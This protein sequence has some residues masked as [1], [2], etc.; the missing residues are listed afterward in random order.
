MRFRYSAD[1]FEDP[2]D[3]VSMSGEGADGISGD[4]RAD[5]LA[6]RR[7]IERAREQGYLSDEEQADV[8][9]EPGGA[10]AVDAITS[11]LAEMNVPVL[12][13]AEDAPDLPD[14]AAVEA[15]NDLFSTELSDV[16]LSGVSLDDPVRIYLREIGR[17]QLLPGAQEVALAQAME[18][19]DYIFRLQ[20]EL[21]GGNGDR[22]S[23]AGIGW[24]VYRTLREGWPLTIAFYRAAFPDQPATTKTRDLAA[25]LP[26]TE[27][28]E[29]AVQADG[30]EGGVS[31]EGLEE[32]LRGRRSE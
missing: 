29:P 24:T 1:G 10:A 25:V 7:I 11:Q 23:A 17:V 18:R 8:A 15:D 4:D 14:V 31:R 20:Q 12:D 2:V 28:V 9:S 22:P 16:D 6:I 27:E 5:E 32:G 13:P 30:V 21:Q 26:L 19:G 3:P